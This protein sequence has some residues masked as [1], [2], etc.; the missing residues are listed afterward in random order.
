MCDIVNDSTKD[1]S[2]ID[3]FPFGANKKGAVAMKSLIG[4]AAI[5]DIV[6][7]SISFGLRKKDEKANKRGIA[8]FDGIDLIMTLVD[9]GLSCGVGYGIYSPM[10]SSNKNISGSEYEKA[11]SATSNA[12]GNYSTLWIIKTAVALFIPSISVIKTIT[13]KNENPEEG[14][15]LLGKLE[16]VNSACHG[17]LCLVSAFLE[18]IACIEAGKVNG[19]KLTDK[20]KKDKQCFITE[21]VGFICDDACA[22]VDSI[23][24]IAELKNLPFIIVREI[25]ELGYAVSMFTEAGIIDNV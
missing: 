15:K 24:S 9:F 25:F 3:P 5:A 23:I 20:Q 18:I 21:T 11:I 1:N 12:A 17:I 14:N 13:V 6:L 16:M 19:D 8:I 22:V 10:D 7:S 4:I 2:E